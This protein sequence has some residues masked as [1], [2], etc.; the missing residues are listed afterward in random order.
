MFRLRDHWHIFVTKKSQKNT[1]LV[2]GLLSH[3]A[4]YLFSLSE[5]WQMCHQQKL[6]FSV[7]WFFLP[8]FSMVL[9]A[10]KE[11]NKIEYRLS[12]IPIGFHELCHRLL[13]KPTSEKN[14]RTVIK[15]SM[16]KRYTG[17]WYTYMMI[18]LI[19][20]SD[21]YDHWDAPTNKQLYSGATDVAV[22]G[23][24]LTLKGESPC[25]PDR[26]TCAFNPQVSG[27][28]TLKW[29]SLPADLTERPVPSTPR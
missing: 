29:E 27:Q 17:G 26:E 10:R 3:F 25:R 15:S 6:F 11:E 23:I 14:D 1:T 5:I 28:I 7:K 19:S 20:P 13:I 22:K 4:I 9:T 2:V 24:W 8:L 16:Q 12:I 21:E 18:V